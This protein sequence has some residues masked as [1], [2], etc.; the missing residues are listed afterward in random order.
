ME[1]A[2][3]GFEVSDGILFLFDG[4]SEDCNLL[5][6]AFDLFGIFFIFIFELSK[7]MM[8]FFL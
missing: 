7:Q 3:F 2:Y 1:S 4:D 5:L 6:H 8:C